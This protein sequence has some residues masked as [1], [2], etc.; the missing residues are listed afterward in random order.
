M[1]EVIERTTEQREEDANSAA[2]SSASALRERYAELYGAVCAVINGGGEAADR[3]LSK[4][5][6]KHA[7]EASHE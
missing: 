5:F 7:S 3:H 4:V 2:L 6:E 1:C